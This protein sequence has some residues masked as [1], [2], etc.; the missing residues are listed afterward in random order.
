MRLPSTPYLLP[1]RP[2]IAADFEGK[3]S[4]T[5]VVLG[6][7]LNELL[8]A[9]LKVGTYASQMSPQIVWLFAVGN[10]RYRTLLTLEDPRCSYL[11]SHF[12]GIIG[13]RRHLFV[14]CGRGKMGSFEGARVGGFLL[15]KTDSIKPSY[16]V[17]SV[18]VTYEE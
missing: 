11:S 15:K 16:L 2:G 17:I 9:A 13:K 3:G 18:L 1:Y 4:V 12:R 5:S 6:S 10:P 7:L 14:G 8:T